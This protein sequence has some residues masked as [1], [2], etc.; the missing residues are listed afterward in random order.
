MP[1]FLGSIQQQ[2]NDF[3]QGL[4]GG[5]RVKL[6]SV[7]VLSV[8][9]VTVGVYVI[10]KPN[11]VPLFTTVLNEKDTAEVVNKLNEIGVSHKTDSD[12]RLTVPENSKDTAKY[13]LSQA[14]VPKGTTTYAD[15][16]SN[17]KLGTTESD[18][19]RIYV[20]QKAKEV[21]NSLVENSDTISTAQVFFN[22]SENSSFFGDTEKSTAS[23][24]ITP[25]GEL[26][27]TQVEGIARFVA[28]SMQGLDPKNV[29]VVDNNMIVLKD[30]DDPSTAGA[31][32][33][34]TLIQTVKKNKEKEIR[35]VLS[36]QSTEY[37][38]VKVVTNLK[39]DFD[40]EVTDAKTLEPVIDGTGAIINKS[41]KIESLTNGSSGGVPGTDSNTGTTTYPSTDSSSGSS[42]KNSD[43]VTN[44]GYNEKVTKSSKALGQVDLENSTVAVSLYY[45][46]SVD[47]VP[48]QEVINKVINIVSK[49]TGLSSDKISVE[50]F[51][52]A[53]E[54]AQKSSFSLVQ[55]LQKYGAFAL[56]IILI[57]LLAVGV[58]VGPKKIKIEGMPTGL[59]L[60]KL[61][62]AELEEIVMEEKSEVKKQIDKFIKQKPEAVA[63]LL[64]NWLTEDWE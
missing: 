39:L 49:A 50:T 3:W 45:G 54:T 59:K 48:S 24:K 58:F 4:D 47:Q 40:T 5:Q 26:S 42:Y 44:Y 35:D 19:S 55:L 29:E 63:N 8:L 64:R 62:E 15:A 18:K 12:G 11:Y 37:D 28:N 56:A 57:G 1:D 16:V 9:I 30:Y 6:L 22:I 10:S 36:N 60:P 38:D 7:V 21:A 46:R 53:K 2:L 17:T 31:D 33:Q 13:Q 41:E 61:P 20:E 27:P 51:K 43:T 32:K 52:I 14:N 34:Y 25:R 23:V